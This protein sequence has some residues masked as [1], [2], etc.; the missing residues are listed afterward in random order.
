M[1]EGRDD[2]NDTC[3][4]VLS[5]VYLWSYAMRQSKAQSASLHPRDSRLL[6]AIRDGR[7]ASCSKPPR[8]S[9]RY[10]FCSLSGAR[11]WLHGQVAADMEVLTAEGVNSFKFFLAYKGA[12]MVTDDQLV[13]GLTQ[14]KRVGALA[15]VRPSPPATTRVCDELVAT[16]TER[17]ALLYTGTVS[18]EEVG[19]A[20]VTGALLK[21]RC[22]QSQAVDFCLWDRK[23][24]FPD[25]WLFVLWLSSLVWAS[26]DAGDHNDNSASA[27]PTLT[28]IL[29][30]TSRTGVDVSDSR[31]ERG[32]G[33]AR[34]A[35][36][37]R[38]GRAGPRGARAVSP[39]R[40]GRCV[41]SIPSRPKDPRI[42]LRQTR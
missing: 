38:R 41:I 4:H 24:S 20:V 13:H 21:L 25:R 39:L 33:G 14:C 36:N 22:S 11:P 19:V 12:L 28:M 15:Q 2:V 5:R 17:P 8:S 26:F 9:Q 23:S 37:D 34:A 18:F 7:I 16:A 29:T 30:A 1:R 27:C 6:E 35:E 40:A 31:R 10:A 3:V 42:A 32:R